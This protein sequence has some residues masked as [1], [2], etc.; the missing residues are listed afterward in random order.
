MYAHSLSR[1]MGIDVDIVLEWPLKKLYRYMAY[2]IADSEAFKKRQN[3]DKVISFDEIIDMFER[4]G[5][6]LDE[7]S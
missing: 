1:E 5:I 3:K 6:K 7:R 4:D 2:S